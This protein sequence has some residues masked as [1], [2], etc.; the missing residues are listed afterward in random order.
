MSFQAYIGVNEDDDVIVAS[1]GATTDVLS[2]MSGNPGV[3]FVFASSFYDQ[4]K[5]VEGVASVAKGVPIA[6]VSSGG[7]LAP[8]GPV[9]RHSVTVLGLQSDELTFSVAVPDA[10][11]K[12]AYAIGVSLAKN[13]ANKS[14]KMACAFLFL[15]GVAYDGVAAVAG[16]RSVFGENF[17]VFGAGASDTGLYQKTYQYS[18]ES[19]TSGSAVAV[20]ITGPILFSTGVAH[21]WVPIGMPALVTKTSGMYLE[22]L[23]S[24]PAINLYREYFE[25]DKTINFTGQTLSELTYAYPLGVP[26]K[27]KGMYTL[28]SPISV[29][30]NGS[31]RFNANIP[32]NSPL[33]FMVGG[34]EEAI[35]AARF[36]ANTA[37][38]SLHTKPTIAFVFLG[39]TRNKFL[40]EHIG[41]EFA[42][43]RDALGEVPIV[44]FYSFSEIAPGNDETHTHQI[45]PA[46]LHNQSALVVLLGLK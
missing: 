18:N 46:E 12:D 15:D 35:D 21:G 11:S 28:R 31:I 33:R 43:L 4:A 8:N 1:T 30:K 19:M 29:E 45:K 22:H 23:G 40:G 14:P 9:R 26:A 36:A 7:E 13:L 3:L 34:K 24:R 44:G 41:D 17:P 39:Y 10:N 27:T 5:V 20:G 42:S 25:K 6:G 16:V 37:I 32:T 2:K 38:E